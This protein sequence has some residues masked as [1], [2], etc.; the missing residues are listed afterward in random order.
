MMSDFERNIFE[1]VTDNSFLFLKEALGRLLERDSGYQE[2]ENGLL[3]LTCAELQIALELAVRATIIR[4]V[5]IAGVLKDDQKKFSE[6]EILKHYENK[7]LKVE[8]FDKLKNY[9]KKNNATSLLK[10]SIKR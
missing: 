7:T 1:A 4:K 3:T 5:G 2:I 8:D 6:E 10:K 9:L